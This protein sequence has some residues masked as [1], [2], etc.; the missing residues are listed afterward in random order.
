MELAQDAL[1]M[2]SHPSRGAWIEIDDNRWNECST[3]SHPSRG[4]WIEISL[5]I[6]GVAVITGRTPRGVRGLKFGYLNVVT[7]DHVSHP[8]RGAWIEIRP[9]LSRCWFAIVAPLAGCV[10]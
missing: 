10:D 7:I 6:T 9:C 1:E 2:A 5:G 4:A 3:G 8:S